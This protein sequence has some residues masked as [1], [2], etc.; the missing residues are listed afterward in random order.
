MTGT[1][2]R[3]PSPQSAEG[4]QK[5]SYSW[6]EVRKHNSSKDCW[7]VVRGKVYDVSAWAPKHPGGDFIFIRA[8]HDVT[9]MFESYHPL[10]VRAMLDQF[11]IGDLKREAR[12]DAAV[13]FA[14]ESEFYRTL[15]RRVEEHFRTTK[16]KPRGVYRMFLKS[17]SIFAI[18][19]FSYFGAF[20]AFSSIWPSL[21]S[22]L[23]LGL[24]F[25]LVG[26]S[27][28]HD[29]NH[30]A[31]SNQPFL[32]R[33]AGISLDLVG[34]SSFM[35]RQQHDIGH[36]QYTNVDLAD[37]D[38]RVSEKD[39][40]RVTATQPW[41]SY[42]RF[43]HIY[44][45]L[46][47]GLLA[48]KSVLL[49]DFMALSSHSIGN[50]KFD[51]LSWEEVFILFGGKVFFFTYM[52]A[53]P[54]YFVPWWH[55]LAVFI[56]AEVVTG[57]C[58]AFM[59]QVAHVTDD[60]QYPLASKDKVVQG[61]WA[62]LQVMTTANF[63]PQSNFWLYM[64][65]GLN[66]QIEHHLFPSISHVLYPQIAPI[67]QSTCKEFNLPYVSYPTFLTALGAHFK[68]LQ[69]IGTGISLKDMRLGD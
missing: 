21:A 19:L 63:S 38:I 53:I 30:G 36:H 5:R 29:G 22:A 65:G 8:G 42:Q 66:Y 49:D 64:S 20:F 14:P 51:P 26:V 34:A 23:F 67:V 39:V 24:G 50:V 6:D 10:Y 52:M 55:V 61:D 17:L 54:S 69:K 31:Y 43:Q 68:Y 27:I 4:A 41:H 2:I 44:L 62:S 12:N 57:Y 47:Y 33:L 59:F 18:V 35:W 1:A 37:P 11:C 46:L 60:V 45:G 15:K 9:Q 13:D 58:L 25:A 3:R 56:V 16:S 40:R 28:Q 32:C 7:L 48:L